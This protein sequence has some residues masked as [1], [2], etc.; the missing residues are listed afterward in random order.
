[1]NR[2]QVNPSQSYWPLLILVRQ[3]P[4][5]S[6]FPLVSPPC[7]PGH[8]LTFSRLQVLT[9]SDFGRQVHTESVG[10]K[11][12]YHATQP[13]D[14]KHGP[15]TPCGRSTIP[16]KKCVIT[17]PHCVARRVD[18]FR[19]PSGWQNILWSCRPTPPRGR[20][21]IGRPSIWRGCK[22]H[23]CPPAHLPA[24]EPPRPR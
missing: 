15:T 20:D 4:P 1:M 10:P 9:C 2:Q 16:S 11:V 23:R 8:R 5:L 21:S 18:P 12:A 19:F 7:V 17:T 24:V 22:T 3:G 6:F 14:E 13:N